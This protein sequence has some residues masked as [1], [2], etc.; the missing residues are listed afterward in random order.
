MERTI[1]E[2]L[3]WRLVE[4]ADRFVNDHNA[5]AKED[6]LDLTDPAVQK[7]VEESVAFFLHEVGLFSHQTVDG[8]HMKA[9]VVF[10]K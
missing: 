5:V 4:A 9:T 1:S 10:P 7:Q 6:G 2:E 8:H 3:Q